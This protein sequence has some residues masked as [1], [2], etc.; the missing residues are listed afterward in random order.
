MNF[1][2]LFREQNFSTTDIS[3]IF[4]R[5]TTKF[6]NVGVWPCTGSSQPKLTARISW[7][8]VRASRDT[9]RR[10]ASVLHWYTCKVGFRQLPYVCQ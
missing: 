5:S 9:M 7:T 3:H 6:G 8:L 1:S 2:L 4:C 10:H